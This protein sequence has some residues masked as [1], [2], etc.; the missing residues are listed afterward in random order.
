MPIDRTSCGPEPWRQHWRK[1]GLGGN[2][3][4][5]RSG[6]TAFIAP[7]PR[8][9]LPILAIFHLKRGLGPPRGDVP[10]PLLP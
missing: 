3:I 4:Y 1:L 9:F 5:C 2:D 6:S 8:F 7:A 10:A